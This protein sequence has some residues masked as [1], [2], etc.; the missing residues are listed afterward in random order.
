MA[1]IWPFEPNKLS[2]KVEW[3]TSV[4]KSRTTEQR[5]KLRLLYPRAQIKITSLLTETETMLA[6][7][8]ARRA[9]GSYLVP[10]W[11]YASNVSVLFDSSSLDIAVDDAFF[12]PVAGD[13]AVAWETVSQIHQFTIDTRGSNTLAAIL[14][15]PIGMQ[16]FK[17]MP[18]FTAVSLGKIDITQKA[19]N[20]N[21]V[22]ITL[23]TQDYVDLESFAT[24][25]PTYLTFEVNTTRDIIQGSN[26]ASVQKFMTLIDNKTGLVTQEE[27][28]DHVDENLTLASKAFGQTAMI[29]QEGW[30]H[31]R[32][33][34]LVPFWKPTW[35]QDLVLTAGASASATTLTA[36]ALGKPADY[37]DR[38]F[39]VDQ[40][41]D[42][43]Y[44]KVI[45]A[46]DDESGYGVGYGT[47]Y[48]GA[49]YATLL[50][51]T[52]DVGLTDAI[53]LAD[54]TTISELNLVRLDTDKVDFKYAPG[55]TSRINVP[56]ESLDND[57]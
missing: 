54:V 46:S 33:G 55:I 4:L 7:A 13:R 47:G 57:L 3:F 29:Q 16:N 28:F 27:K 18:L 52:L 42:F 30:V 53:V 10:D 40:G 2:V 5:S 20:V 25:Y 36:F 50:T 12:Y 9:E 39:I 23:Q 26:K 45:A 21:S 51:L 41:G 48:G 8:I 31:K 38:H 22:T 56:L 1:E 44:F 15:P 34:R 24:S 35:G 32:Y 37:V 6:R 43:Q 14:G 19:N 17:V 49:R 11:R